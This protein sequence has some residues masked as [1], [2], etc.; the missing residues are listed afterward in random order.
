MNAVLEN[1]EVSV[2]L[3]NIRIEKEVFIIKKNN[4]VDRTGHKFDYVKYRKGQLNASFT[5]N[6]SIKVRWR[7]A[8]VPTNGKKKAGTEKK[9]QQIF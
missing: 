6:Q 8:T 2:V 9:H 1:K 4:R 3:L 7:T 5:T